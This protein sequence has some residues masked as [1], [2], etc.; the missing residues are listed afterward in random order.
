MVMEALTYSTKKFPLF[1]P[2]ANISENKRETPRD[3]RSFT[4]LT[5][6]C[7]LNKA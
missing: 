5:K 4:L 3:P 6:Q 7:A 2:S 1:F